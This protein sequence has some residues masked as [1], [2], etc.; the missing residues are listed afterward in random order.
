MKSYLCINLKDFHSNQNGA[1]TTTQIK[2]LESS[3]QEQAEKDI[4]NLYPDTP[5][6]VVPKKYCDDRIVTCK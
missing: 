4:H 5:W 3:N 1:E 6:F 2:F